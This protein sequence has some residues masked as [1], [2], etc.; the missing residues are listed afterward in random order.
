MAD[1]SSR[2]IRIARREAVLLAIAL[3]IGAVL[4]PPAVYIVGQA[5]FGA[6]AGGGFGS[7]YA[8]LAARLGAAETFAWFLVLSPYLAVQTLRATFL[9]WRLTARPKA[10]AG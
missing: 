7:F 5:V 4:L 6:F 3:L 9:A 2:I 10:G 8:S 1:N